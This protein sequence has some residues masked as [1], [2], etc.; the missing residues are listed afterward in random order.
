MPIRNGTIRAHPAVEVEAE[1]VAAGR[2]WNFK[3]HAA[4]GIS[5]ALFAGIG[6]HARPDVGMAFLTGQAIPAIS[7][8]YVTQDWNQYWMLVFLG[9]NSQRKY[10]GHWVPN[11]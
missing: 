9:N 1:V 6:A 4:T 8:V 11:L 10:V 2:R 7:C 3:I 5:R